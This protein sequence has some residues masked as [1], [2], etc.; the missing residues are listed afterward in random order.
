[1]EALVIA[2]E[3]LHRGFYAC[4]GKRGKKLTRTIYYYYIPTRYIDH[5]CKY[6]EVNVRV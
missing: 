5:S 6:L 4:L 3:T 1:M 2:P